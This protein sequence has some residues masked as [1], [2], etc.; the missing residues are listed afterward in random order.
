[1]IIRKIKQAMKRYEYLPIFGIGPAY[2][3]S[4]LLPTLAVVLLRDNHVFESGKLITLRIPLIVI[5]V[6]LIILSAFIWTQAVI[7][8]KLDENIKKN[9]L[10]TSGVYSWVRNPVYSAFM[11]LCTGIILV[12]GNAWFFVLPFLYWQLLA[13]LIKHTEEKWLKDRYGKAYKEYCRNVNRCWPWLPKKS[14]K[15]WRRGSVVS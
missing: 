12:A 15:N 9:H 4:I 7:V 10:V 2:V 13:V 14:E 5:G 11:L 6:L 1:M 3:V 8:S